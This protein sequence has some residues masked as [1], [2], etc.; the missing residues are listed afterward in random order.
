[1]IAICHNGEMMWVASL[2]GHD[3]CKVIAKDVGPVDAP[4]SAC[5]KTGVAIVDEAEVERQ[6]INAMTNMELIAEIMARLKKR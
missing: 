6:R 3:G 5:P 2:D 4:C 1:M